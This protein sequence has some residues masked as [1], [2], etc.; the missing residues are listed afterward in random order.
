LTNIDKI[1]TIGHGKL[2]ILESNTLD[3]QI[4]N[5]GPRINSIKKAYDFKKKS[6][7][8]TYDLKHPRGFPPFF[9]K[10][11]EK[12]YRMQLNDK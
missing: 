4:G 11:C 9:S 10:L 8:T 6:K 7:W 12:I 5:C 3:L 2:D 1:T